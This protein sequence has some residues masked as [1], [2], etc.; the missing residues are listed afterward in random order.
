MTLN[1]HP[2]DYPHPLLTIVIVFELI[3]HAS[4][5]QSAY[6]VLFWAIF[7]YYHDRAGRISEK[8]G[9]KLREDDREE[10]GERE[11]RGE[12]SVKERERKEGGEKEREREREVRQ[13]RDRDTQA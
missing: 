2:R 3:P 6:F 9:L 13:T 11:R 10:E 12:G 4:L 8:R 1:W 5:P 7:C